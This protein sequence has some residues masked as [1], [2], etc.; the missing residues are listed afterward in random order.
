MTGLVF[1]CGDINGIGPEIIIKTINKISSPN[2]KNIIIVCPVNAFE[3]AASI[4]APSFNYSVI[5]GQDTVRNNHGEVL[6]INT[7]KVALTPGIPTAKSGAA[8]YK[9]LLTALSIVS[10]SSSSALITAPLSKH[11]FELAGIPY[12]GHTEILGEYCNTD[13]FLMTFLS[14]RMNAALLTIHVPVSQVAGM[15]TRD[16]IL[17][18]LTI[19]TETWIKDFGVKSPS[20]AVLGLNPHS[21]E[22]GRIGREEEEIIKPAI[23]E[24]SRLTAHQIKG[25][26]VP[27]AFF[28]NK[29]YKKFDVVLSM[30]HDQALIPFK[31]LN[32]TD[33][34]NYTAGLPIVRTSPDHGTAFDIA[35]KGVASCSSMLSACRYAEKIIKERTKYAR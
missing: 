10:A 1:T 11:A 13:K 22:L 14:M 5:K 30:Y 28:A 23:S 31:L 2:K 19:L 15:I 35:Y 4:A 24:F 26:F 34:V 17:N 8:A 6:L 3:K 12:S 20:I 9:A 33:G 29:L 7:G 25:P 27:D 18:A 21:G 16:K 32:F